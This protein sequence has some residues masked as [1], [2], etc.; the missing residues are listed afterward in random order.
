MVPKTRPKKLEQAREELLRVWADLGPA[1]GVNRTMSQVHALLMISREAMNTDQIMAELDIS[2]G[3]G[4]K[5]IKELLEWGLLKRVPVKGELK[6]YFVAEKDVWKVVQI[7]TRERKRKELQP[8]FEVLEECLHGTK[9][10]R[11][12][13]SKAFRAQLAELQEFAQLADG[14]MDR[15]GRKSS[16]FI[17]P[18]ALTLLK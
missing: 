9:G 16:K 6:A 13:E 4:H 17:L 7:I 14:V 11:D 18:W 15:V 10:L 3:N 5:N 2:R 1:W 12:A 8:M